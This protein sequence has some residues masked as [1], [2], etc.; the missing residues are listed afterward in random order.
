MWTSRE[1]FKN[2]KDSLIKRATASPEVEIEVSLI[3]HISFGGRF[4]ASISCSRP[5][6]DHTEALGAPK[7]SYLF[8]VESPGIA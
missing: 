4:T 7:M 1:R 3:H 6:C 2:I 5:L 8:D